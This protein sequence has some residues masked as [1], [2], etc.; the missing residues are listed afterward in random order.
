MIAHNFSKT[1][2]A[3]LAHDQVGRVPRHTEIRIPRTLLRTLARRMG[4][5]LH[6]IHVALVVK[7]LPLGM[8]KLTGVGT[9][10]DQPVALQV[11]FTPI[12]VVKALK[13][14]KSLPDKLLIAVAAIDALD[15]PGQNRNL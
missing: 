9:E 5:H 12:P 14:W 11:A 4:R 13:P 3:L 2:K 15:P 1:H 6:R 10:C 8:L 7:G